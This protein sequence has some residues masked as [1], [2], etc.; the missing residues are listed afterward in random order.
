MI[1]RETVPQK[2]GS[3]W[4]Y[5]YIG[6]G[7]VVLTSMGRELIHDDPSI[8]TDIHR[9]RQKRLGHT[10]ALGSE[11]VRSHFRSGGN[12]DVYELREGSGLVVKETS[13]AQAM[14]FALL[15]MD[16]LKTI[17]ESDVPRWI[18]IPAHYGL[19]S[20]PSSTTDYMLMEKIDA[21]I[22]VG[23]VVDSS[24]EQVRANQGTLATFGPIDE[25]VKQE[26]SDRFTR[27]KILL[28][29]AILSHD[30]LPVDYLP[31]WDASNVLVERL[32]TPMAG[33]N[34]MLWVIDQ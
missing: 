25:E 21:G 4:Q 20:S 10:A 19:I 28:D 24:C 26:V 31:D 17:I 32:E 15:R 12:S 1:S 14:Y 16:R 2:D 13:T 11:T 18:D 8:L 22:T 9:Y 6:N 34:Y 23:D 27:A 30:L 5:Y 7:V 33:S 3:L 29:E